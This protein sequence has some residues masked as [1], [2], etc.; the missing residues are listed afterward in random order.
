MKVVAEGVET[1]PQRQFLWSIGCNAMQ[2]YLFGEAVPAAQLEPKL[3][4]AVA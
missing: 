2:G 1:D 3:P 4:K